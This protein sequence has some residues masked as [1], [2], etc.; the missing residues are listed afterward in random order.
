MQYDQAC[1]EEGTYHQ[2]RYG[3]TNNKKVM[4]MSQIYLTQGTP[5]LDNNQ[6]GFSY[7]LALFIPIMF[8]G[9]CATDL[10]A[11]Y[12]LPIEG[13]K[14]A[15]LQYHVHQRS[16]DWIKAEILE[17]EDLKQQLSDPLTKGKPTKRSPDEIDTEL[18]KWQTILPKVELLHN[19]EQAKREED[20]KDRDIV[21]N[22]SL[23]AGATAGVASTLLLTAATYGL[24]KLYQRYKNRSKD[25]DAK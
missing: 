2:W 4:L 16:P 22:F 11:A 3:L 17:L 18:Q 6:Y 7:F 13:H 14:K 12:D 5:M 23:A 9:L 10:Q 20:K 8:F 1:E 21:R 24:I 15:L 19:R 25:P